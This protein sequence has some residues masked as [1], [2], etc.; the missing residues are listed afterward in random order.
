MPLRRSLRRL[1]VTP[2]K[3]LLL[4]GLILALSVGADEVRP[5]FSTTL[6]REDFAAAG[7][8]KLSADERAKLDE[9][10]AGRAST[11]PTKAISAAGDYV[12]AKGKPDEFLAR[13][14]VLLKPG[15]EVEYKIEET[16]L[17]G[18]FNGWQT[19][20]VF[21]LG[22]GQ[23]WQALNGS[24]VTGRQPGSRKL[25]IVPGV[26]GSFFLEIEGVRQK[27]KVKFGGGA[28]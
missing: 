8:G 1:H 10:I 21:V 23:R 6:R 18:D 15:T 13:A 14:K 7:L 28:G 4:A 9:L 20:T 19:G 16:S 22:N 17:A 24:Y 27:P 2:V 5:G 26:L 11:A 12:T 25:R 3:R